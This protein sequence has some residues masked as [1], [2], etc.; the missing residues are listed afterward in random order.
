MTRF[1]LCVEKLEERCGASPEVVRILN[2]FCRASYRQLYRLLKSGE[3]RRMGERL[4]VLECEQLIGEL[5]AMQ[6][7]V[8][9]FAESTPAF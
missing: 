1:R 4:S 5:K 3:L 9:R 8:E 6:R 7:I 2:L